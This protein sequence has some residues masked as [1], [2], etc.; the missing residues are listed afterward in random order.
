[1]QALN[2]I[3]TPIPGFEGDIPILISAQTP[4]NK[5]ANDSSASPGAGSSRNRAGKRKATA[6]PPPQKK[7]KKVMG[8]T[9]SEIKI[10]EPTPKPSSPPTP[11]KGS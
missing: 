8:K 1:M 7:A 11:P 5:S 4:N 10:N 3:I 9:A 2:N 6:T